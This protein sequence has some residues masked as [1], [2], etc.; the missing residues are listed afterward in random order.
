MANSGFAMRKLFQSIIVFDVNLE[1]V[2]NKFFSHIL[3]VLKK[4]FFSK[5]MVSLH[6]FFVFT[7]I[8]SSGEL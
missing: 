5:I 4:T 8:I 1:K 6:C 7:M 3:Y 2:E